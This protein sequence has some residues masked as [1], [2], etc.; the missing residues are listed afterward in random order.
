MKICIWNWNYDSVCKLQ[1]VGKFLS[2]SLSLALPSLSHVD[3]G[4]A[5]KL[6][7]CNTHS[8]LHSTGWQRQWEA[9]WVTPLANFLAHATSSYEC[10][11]MSFL[12]KG[13][14]VCRG[15][16]FKVN[17]VDIVS[18]SYFF[19]SQTTLHYSFSFCG[20]HTRTNTQYALRIH[21]TPGA[22]KTPTGSKRRQQQPMGGKA[23]Q[24]AGCQ[25]TQIN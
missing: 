14:T 25:V 12:S 5:L 23:V 16:H 13:L 3:A 21:A 24:P 22:A 15:A 10:L 11:C 9:G 8:N 19:L 7:I 17:Y 18:S 6:I 20:T 2:L 4:N 1:W